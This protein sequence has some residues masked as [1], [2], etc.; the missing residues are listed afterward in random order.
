[1]AI[2][3]IIP[4]TIEWDAF[5]ANHIKRYQFAAS[6]IPIENDLIILD[7]ACG[8]GY[9]SFL[10][11]SIPN[12]KIIAIDR[13]HVALEIA[14]STYSKDN[15]QYLEDDCHTLG[16]SNSFGPFDVIVSFE[17]LE[18]LPKPDKFLKQCYTNLQ[19]GGKL[20]IST[21]NQ[22]VSSK[23]NLQKW[24]F[25][26]KEYTPHDFVSI[27]QKAGF[28]S[29]QLFGQEL[30]SIGKLRK[31]FRSELNTILSNPFIRIGQF[32]QRIFKGHIFSTQLPEQLEDFDIV[33]YENYSSID[34]SSNGPFV[35][36]A[37][38]EKS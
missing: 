25:H 38:C 28:L 3:R 34:T 30:T 1:M 19:K 32:I 2:E 27:L 4:G 15:V 14:R 33:P 16:N 5:F 12:S 6:Q 20:I 13:S 17:T 18:H 24:E 23:E 26:E 37:V 22:I 29:I 10:L 35:L 21:P 31:Q 11:S 7:A 8:V 36:L 9:G